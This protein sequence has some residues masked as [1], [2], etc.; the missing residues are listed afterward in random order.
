MWW[1]IDEMGVLMNDPSF[2]ITR[3]RAVLLDCRVVCKKSTNKAIRLEQEALALLPEVNADNALLVTNLNATF[4]GLYRETKQNDDGRSETE[5]A[6]SVLEEYR[7]I[8]GHDCFVRFENFAMLLNDK[9][10]AEGG[11]SDFGRSNAPFGNRIQA[12]STMQRS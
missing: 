11:F 6:N 7:L 10:Q 9:G 5:S 1:L 12:P 2:G 3:D 8:G 4:G